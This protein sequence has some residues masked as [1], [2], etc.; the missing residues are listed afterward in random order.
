MMVLGVVELNRVPVKSSE[1]HG[2]AWR[3][4]I[5]GRLGLTHNSPMGA[6]SADLEHPAQ[7]AATLGGT[8]SQRPRQA[9]REPGQASTQF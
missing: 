2:T 6:T 9:Q 8:T 7:P 3:R 4:T 1:T 5:A